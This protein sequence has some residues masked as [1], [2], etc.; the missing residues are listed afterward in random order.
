MFLACRLE[1]ELFSIA[2]CTICNHIS[3]KVILSAQFTHL[4][5]A[6]SHFNSVH[7]SHTIGNFFSFSNIFNNVCNWNIYF[8]FNKSWNNKTKNFKQSCKNHEQREKV[9]RNNNN[10]NSSTK[11]REWKT[12][13]MQN[14]EDMLIT[15]SSLSLFAYC[16]NV[17][18][19]HLDGGL[20]RLISLQNHTQYKPQLGHDSRNS[21]QQ[22]NKTATKQRYM[23]E[24]A[25]LSFN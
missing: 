4:D 23:E 21:N 24:S 20:L 1:I 11:R 14:T 17:P 6:I 9:K 8:H 25:G 5:F 19:S 7:T 2:F 3:Y 16:H 12:R 22:Q 10:H 15:T 13:I 18:S